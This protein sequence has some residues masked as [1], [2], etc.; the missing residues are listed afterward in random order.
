MTLLHPALSRRRALAL[1]G[2]APLGLGLPARR[3][4]A[5][6][7]GPSRSDLRLLRRVD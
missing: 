2:M 1:L 6:D 7:H 3:R 4:A 5:G